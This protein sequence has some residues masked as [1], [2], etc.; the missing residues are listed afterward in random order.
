MPK[1]GSSLWKTGKG[2]GPESEL[3]KSATTPS[4]VITSKSPPARSPK[5]KTSTDTS[6]NRLSRQVKDTSQP[7]SKK[8]KTE[9]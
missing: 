6:E 4:S 9:S 1:T 3:R 2:R 8:R 7:N 5:S